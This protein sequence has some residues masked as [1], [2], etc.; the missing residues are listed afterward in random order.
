MD[1]LTRLAEYFGRLPGIGPRQS[2]RFVHFL[3]S[4][5]PQFH[6]DFAALIKDLSKGVTECQS[7]YRYFSQNSEIMEECP[8]CRNPNKNQKLLMVLEKDVDLD[9][10][11][12]GGS[13]NGQYFILG[14]T[15]PVLEN[16]PDKKIRSQLLLKRIEDGKFKEIILALSA[17]PDG[18]STAT[19]VGELLKD[20]AGKKKLKIST[21]GRGLSTGSELEYSDTETI[22]NALNNR[23]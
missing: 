20:I 5:P 18:D 2:K 22:K 3:L 1:K 4:Q 7:C 21:L 19:Y 23:T 12:R 16:N 15:V 6:A 14:G 10:I 8:I 13:Y 11:E 9:N 17:T